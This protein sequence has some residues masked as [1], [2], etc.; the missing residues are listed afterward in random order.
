MAVLSAYLGRSKVFWMAWILEREEIQ[1]IQNTFGRPRYALRHHMCRTY[2][3]PK[4]SQPTRY[5]QSN[6]YIHIALCFS[7]SLPR[8]PPLH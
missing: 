4:F 3:H 7:L 1:V 2:L 8:N 6:Y 5:E